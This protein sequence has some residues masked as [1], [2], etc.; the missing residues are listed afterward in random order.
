MKKI[1]TYRCEDFKLSVRDELQELIAQE[2]CQ[3]N[4]AAAAEAQPPQSTV[5]RK[6]GGE[7]DS[8]S[9]STTGNSQFGKDSC[10]FEIRD[11]PYIA[12][13]EFAMRIPLPLLL[14]PRTRSTRDFRK[15]TDST[16]EEEEEEEE[17]EDDD[18]AEEEGVDEMLLLL[19][20]LAFCSILRE[21]TEPLLL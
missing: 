18:D 13:H 20:L 19:V 7:V 15:A 12:E 5:M 21:L 9:L 6:G 10:G 4:P 11:I 8:S 14:L 16:E 17:E 3:S 2:Y 1:W